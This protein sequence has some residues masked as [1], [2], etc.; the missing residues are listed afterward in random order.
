VVEPTDRGRQCRIN[1]Q[2][3]PNARLLTRIKD[4]FFWV[5][6]LRYMVMPQWRI[7]TFYCRANSLWYFAEPSSLKTNGG[8]AFTVKVAKGRTAQDAKQC[9]PRFFTIGKRA[10]EKQCLRKLLILKC[11]WK[12][13]QEGHNG[14][15]VNGSHL[16]TSVVV[17]R[18]PKEHT[19]GFQ[20]L[21]V[22]K[23]M[24]DHH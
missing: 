10:F 16:I 6:L 21:Q 15:W 5:G 11:I 22:R 24:L 9:I 12:E 18:Y 8:F 13:G 2:H 17:S 23:I 3:G 20:L 19:I 4:D 1:Q 14:G 7:T